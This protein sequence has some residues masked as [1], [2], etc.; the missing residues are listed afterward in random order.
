MRFRSTRRQAPPVG[1]SDALAHGLAPDGGLYVPTRWPQLDVRLLRG[2]ALQEAACLVL[3]PFFAGDRLERELGAIA[4]R[5][6]SFP[7]PLSPLE[8]GAVLELFHGPTAAFKD[9]GA[10]FLAGCLERTGVSR[11]TVLVATSGDTGSAVAAALE[12]SQRVDVGILF[13]IAGVSR[14]QRHLLSC[15]RDNVRCFA[16]RGTFDDCQ[17]LLKTAL[18]G[19]WGGEGE[20]TT[21]NSINIAR[22]LPQTV[23]Y[24]VAASRYSE[25][26]GA[27]PDFL[28]PTGNL[29]NA[30]ACLWAKRMGLPIGRVVL[31]TNEN[32]TIADYLATGSWRPR[33]PTRTLAN[34]MDVG[35]PSNMQRVLDL[36]PA[37]PDLLR[38]VESVVVS[39]AEIR[40]TIAAG[41][42][43]RG[44]VWDPHT[45][46]AVRALERQGGGHRIVVATA[47]AAKFP[48]VVEPLIDGAVKVAPALQA[49]LARPA[50][51]VEIEPGLDALDHAW[52]SEAEGR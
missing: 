33:A 4:E 32:R 1:L 19:G 29:G 50:R 48:D 31:V 39:D 44:R 8:D 28:V 14:A 36:Y 9:V 25:E 52:R 20:L 35:D 34:A 30:T 16:V 43:R 38:D 27:A 37:L 7:I 24:A 41:P 46:T 10:R 15:W 3:A 11:R 51:A 5:A 12:G 22:L 40:Q 18:A 26:H 49:L 45:A 23:Y 6:F 13:P 47:H 17:R 2:L 42:A 21:A